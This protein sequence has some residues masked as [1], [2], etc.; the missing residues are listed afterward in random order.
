M[1]ISNSVATKI[2]KMNRA[3]ADAVL[4]TAFQ[5]AQTNIATLQGQVTALEVGSV[6]TAGSVQVSAAQCGASTVIINTGLG[7]SYGQV[8]TILR[9][10]SLLVPTSASEIK[11]SNSSGSITVV[12]MLSGILMTTDTIHWFAF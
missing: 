4:G 7:T 10:G 3:S 8:L 11:V 5:T 2:N 12:G 1:A 9:S 6:V